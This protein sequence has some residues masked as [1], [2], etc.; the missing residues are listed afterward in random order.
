MATSDPIDSLDFLR[1]ADRDYLRQLAQELTFGSVVLFAGAGLSFNAPCKDGG[2][3]VMPGWKQLAERLLQQLEGSLKDEKDPLKV[4][5]YYQTRFGRAALIETLVHTVRDT[6][7]VPG[8]VHDC[9]TSLNFEEIITTNYDTLIERAFERRYIVPQVIV[10]SR[11]LARQRQPPR[12]IKMSGC[13]KINQSGVVITG[14]DFLAYADRHPLVQILVTRSFIESTVLFIGF[15]LNDPA[16]RAINQRVLSTLGRDDC[17][18]AFSLQHGAS[19]T[20]ISYWKQRQVQIIDLRPPEM[21][22]CLDNEQRLNRVLTQLRE[23]QRA[24]ARAWR[25]RGRRPLFNLGPVAATKAPAEEGS[26]LRTVLKEALRAG[27][28]AELSGRGWPAPEDCI[29]RIVAELVARS[30]APGSVGR[31]GALEELVLWLREICRIDDLDTPELRL[32]A[33][34]WVPLFHLLR[35][36]VDSGIAHLEKSAMA[37]HQLADLK[38]LVIGL[39]FKTLIVL[40]SIAGRNRERSEEARSG[41]TRLFRDAARLLDCDLL[42]G[43]DMTVRARLI[44]LL[45]LF[46][47]VARMRELVEVWTGFGEEAALLHKPGRTVQ[48][49]P[50]EYRVF[51]LGFAGTLRDHPVFFQKAV[52]SLWARQTFRQGRQEDWRIENAF[53]YRYLRQSAPEAVATWSGVRLHQERL[54]RVLGRLSLDAESG[55]EECVEPAAGRSSGEGKPPAC[56]AGSDLL[57]PARESAGPAPEL[58]DTL[59]ELSRGWVFGVAPPLALDRAWQAAAELCDHEHFEEVPWEALLLLTLPLDGDL[60]GCRRRLLDAA[61]RR[62]CLDVS[63][64]LAHIA[65]RLDDGAFAEVP[66]AA[67]QPKERPPIGRYECALALLVRWL[68]G[69]IAS[70]EKEDLR[71]EMM[72]RLLG[73]VE[74]WL[75]QTTS[76]EVQGSL[77]QTVAQFRAWAPERVGP[78]VKSWILSRRQRLSERSLKL[79]LLDPPGPSPAVEPKDVAFL[80][81]HAADEV[82]TGTSFRDDLQQW[83]LGWSRAQP[84]GAEIAA[85]LALQAARWLSPKRERKSFDWLRLAAQ[86]R[87][88]EPLFAR[89]S[90]H[91]EVSSLYEFVKGK[92]VNMS[93]DERKRWEAKVSFLGYLAPFAAEF[94]PEL[95][96]L[97][98]RIFEKPGM[99]AEG[100]EGAVV[101]LVAL[102][103]KAPAELRT[104][105][106]QRWF[107]VLGRLI[108]DQGA[109]GHGKLNRQLWEFDERTRLAVQDHLIALLQRDPASGVVGWIAQTIRDAEAA[110]VRLEDL[111]EQWIETVQ[112]ADHTLA[113][114]CLQEVSKLAAEMPDFAARHCRRLQRVLREL[115]RRGGYRQTS[116]FA[117]LIERLARDPGGDLT[118]D[119]GSPMAAGLPVASP[120]DGGATRSRPG[121]D[122]AAPAPVNRR[123]KPRNPARPVPGLG[124][125]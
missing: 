99:T 5:D 73:P 49:T 14:D 25:P 66:R 69:Q 120:S 26:P 62:G 23:A 52:E 56:V 13:F 2:K 67:S 43:N 78:L 100:A 107:E 93:D 89:I 80:L 55:G 34:D 47:P 19:E 111:E 115:R 84:L 8:R 28:S 123:R 46:A 42:T 20:E 65:V 9:I 41:A 32:S 114:E 117:A 94:D 125:P 1:P 119:A 116:R 61:W 86:I 45:C 79:T 121:G 76:P 112:S 105:W 68:A 16:F 59:L 24:G 18:L 122:P 22:V 36:L 82:T 30:Q 64:L 50:E 81:A 74:T 4:A 29:D 11:D 72:D 98:Q 106:H 91:L 57:A 21:P 53:R 15:G 48:A 104:S 10:E 35:R 71:T 113:A 12:I 17:R 70:E 109:T 40:P 85:A 103:E 37:N 101:L 97:V 58:L 87:D 7:H 92:L 118:L 51:A 44:V 31:G 88:D 108:R 39:S 60:T 54:E 33:A 110:G 95:S 63:F 77:I 124:S 38:I 75:C 102:L 6:E 83:L 3:N 90:N 27:N 96:G